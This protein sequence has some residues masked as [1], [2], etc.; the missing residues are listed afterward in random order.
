MNV[1]LV[2]ARGIGMLGQIWLLYQKAFPAAEKKPFWMILKRRKQGGCEILS[3]RLEDG[4][5]G[6]LAITML[7]QDLVLLDYFAVNGKRRGKGIGSASLKAIQKR[8]E[9]KRL[10]LE[11]ESPEEKCQNLEERRRRKHFYLKNGM[12]Q[13]G[14]LVLLFQIEMEVLAYQCSLSFEEY[15]A[16]Y[17]DMFKEKAGDKVKKLTR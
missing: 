4:S 14:L 16:L 6:G 12:T 5:F 13:T 10:F 7:Y 2:P 9:G 17:E 8:Y 15:F 1:E 11:I 3:L